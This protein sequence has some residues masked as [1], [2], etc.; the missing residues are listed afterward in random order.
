MRRVLVALALFIGLV[1]AGGFLF[2]NALLLHA[3]GIIDGVLNPVAENHAVPW[4]DG[5]G[6][7]EAPPAARPPNI[8]L[9]VADDLGWNDLSLHGGGVGHGRVATPSIDSIAQQGV[10]FTN[11]YSGAAS[12]AP[13]R[14]ALMSGRYGTRFGFEFTPVLPGMA[15]RLVALSLERKDRLRYPVYIEHA[16]PSLSFA[17]MGREKHH[18]VSRG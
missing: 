18:T 3:P 8:V 1:A 17:E 16:G 2:R 10:H 11:G 14:A 9:I 7:A 5:P 6:T 13:S 15:K 12:C 4:Q